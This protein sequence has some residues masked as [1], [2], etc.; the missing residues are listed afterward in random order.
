MAGRTQAPS[1]GYKIFRHGDELDPAKLTFEPRKAHKDA[2]K[3]HYGGDAVYVQTNSCCL[4]T[5]LVYDGEVQKTVDLEMFEQHSDKHK[6][7]VRKLRVIEEAAEAYLKTLDPPGDGRL[8]KSAMRN[9]QRSAKGSQPTFRASGENLTVEDI[10]F[11]EDTNYV[12]PGTPIMAMLELA[13]L[14]RNAEGRGVLS[15]ALYQVKV[16]QDPEKAD[17]AHGR[18]PKAEWGKEDNILGTDRQS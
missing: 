18:P 14:R 2:L 4:K 6:E 17:D 10:Q 13:G 3:V 9:L 8:L 12:E 11:T 5:P 7:V 15:W 1:L 16:L